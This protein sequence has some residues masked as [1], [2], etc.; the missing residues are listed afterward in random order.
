MGRSLM[1]DGFLVLF[2]ALFFLP[3]LF[4]ILFFLAIASS[5][6]ARQTPH[7]FNPC[8]DE[9]EIFA[10]P[11]VS[12]I[13]SIFRRS[14][15]PR[16]SHL[17][18]TE[19]KNLRRGAEGT[20]VTCTESERKSSSKRYVGE[21]ERHR[22]LSRAG[23]FHCFTRVA[24]SRIYPLVTTGGGA[25]P[26]PTYCAQPTTLRRANIAAVARASFFIELSFVM[27]AN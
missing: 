1:V 18:R 7:D 17:L 15:R 12:T 4:A 3:L 21:N 13:C 27:T 9:S 2:D 22:L 24:P 25:L 14:F 5:S 23:P 19:N 8:G 11:P 10:R 20:L 16:L 26:L 6:A